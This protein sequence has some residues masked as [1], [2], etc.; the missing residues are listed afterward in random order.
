MKTLPT[1]A[2]KH[3]ELRRKRTPNSVPVHSPKMH[4]IVKYNGDG[5][6]NPI[7]TRLQELKKKIAEKNKV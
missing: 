6:I 7:W 1:S 4:K 3:K 5:S 2:K